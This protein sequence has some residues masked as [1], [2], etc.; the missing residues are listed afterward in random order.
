MKRSPSPSSGNLPA[1][2]SRNYCAKLP[3]RRPCLWLL[4]RI[5]T[6]SYLCRRALSEAQAACGSLNFANQDGHDGEPVD[7]DCALFSSSRDT[8]DD[9]TFLESSEMLV[10]NARA[11]FNRVKK[12]M[13]RAPFSTSH[14]YVRWRSHISAKVSWET[15]RAWRILRMLVPKFISS[16]AII[17]FNTIYYIAQVDIHNKSYYTAVNALS[18]D[19]VMQ[20]ISDYCRPLVTIQDYNLKKH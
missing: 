1:M 17:G 5:N 4:N 16:G 7:T 2:T 12:L 13:S 6:S 18:S 14:T 20:T 9:S 11:I 3:N 10:P 8:L 15:L 19:L